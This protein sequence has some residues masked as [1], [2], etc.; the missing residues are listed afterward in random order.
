ML[1][2]TTLICILLVFL[3]GC[4]RLN[5]EYAGKWQGIEAPSD[6]LEITPNGD[7]FIVKG[8]DT[9]IFGYS[10]GPFKSPASVGKDGLSFWSGN[11]HN[12]FSYVHADDTLLGVG[13]CCMSNTFKRIK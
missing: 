11:G 3:S 10:K 8:K 7:G 2:A 9:A 4:S 5:S 1:R 13:L 6:I 12:Q